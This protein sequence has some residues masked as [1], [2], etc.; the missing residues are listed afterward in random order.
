MSN[1]Y[2]FKYSA[3]Y[4]GIVEGATEAEAWKNFYDNM[5]DFYVDW[6]AEEEMEQADTCPNCDGVL[7]PDDV[8][9]WMDECDGDCEESDDEDEA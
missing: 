1:V 6:S 5:N 2:K 7:N 3:Q 9:C 8:K 4:E